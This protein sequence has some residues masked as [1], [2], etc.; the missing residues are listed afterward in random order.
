MLRDRIYQN[1]AISCHFRP[2]FERT[3]RAF[4][5]GRDRRKKASERTI[6][7]TVEGS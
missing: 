7:P 3:P 4:F 1:P 5:R 2:L 6:T